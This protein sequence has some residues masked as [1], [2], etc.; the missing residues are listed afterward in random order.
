MR[1]GAVMMRLYDRQLTPARVGLIL[2]MVLLLGAMIVRV[3]TASEDREVRTP[4]APEYGEQVT[5]NTGVKGLRGS[6]Q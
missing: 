2:L 1:M 4:T 3:V 6:L 5:P